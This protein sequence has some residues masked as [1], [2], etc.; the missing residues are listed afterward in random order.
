MSKEEYAE[1]HKLLADEFAKVF[2]YFYIWKSLQNRENEPMYNQNPGFWNATLSALE[3]TWLIKL[4]KIYER[5]RFSNDGTVISLYALLNEQSDPIKIMEIERMLVAH[6]SVISAIKE[7]RDNKLAHNNASHLLDPVKLTQEYPV[8]Y[9][10][11]ESL[12]NTSDKLLNLLGSDG[13]TEY[14]H[15]ALIDQCES[16]VEDLVRK[17]KSLTTATI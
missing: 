14:G 2:F 16:D 12:I 11:I 6:K 1:R 7:W 17:L 9:P 8:P 4:G 13:I 5:S 15:A 10:Q 3:D